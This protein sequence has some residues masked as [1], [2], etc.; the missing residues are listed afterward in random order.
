MLINPL[1]FAAAAAVPRRDLKSTLTTTT[2]DTLLR[3][4]SAEPSE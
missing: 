2:P 1:S 3:D 4:C